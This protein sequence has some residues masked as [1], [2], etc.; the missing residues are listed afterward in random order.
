[1]TSAEPTALI[2]VGGRRTEVVV[3]LG[4][5]AVFARTLSR[6]VEGLPATAPL[7]AGELRQTFSAYLA[8]SG[9]SIRG[10]YLVGGGAAAEGAEAY[11]AHQLGIPVSGL[12]ELQLGPV[13]PEQ[14]A[15]VPRFAKAIAL[16][17]SLAP[18]PADVDLRQGELTFQRGYGFLK[19]KI[20][21]LTGLGAAI[22]ISFL[23][24]TWAELRALGREN[25]ALAAALSGLSKEVLAEETSDPARAV[26]LLERAK[27]SE[28]ADPMPHLDA[29]GVIVELSKIIP[30][31]ITHD[32]EE[33]DMQR[34]HVKL[35][36]V[37]GSA[38]DAQL[39]AT[40]IG[41]H[42]CLKDPKVSKVTQVINSDRQKYVLEFDVRC[43]DDASAKKK[44]KPAGGAAT[45]TTE[46][47]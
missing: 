1:L 11:L 27:G 20:P 22:F 46:T 38:A 47:P 43:P 19:D 12:P 7:L 4:G 45:T 39:I 36:G 29:F 33:F 30:N 16:A 35:N 15:L 44:K 6:G 17:L 42:R 28:D 34:G 5:E 25:E 23:F 31:S 26:E 24:S 9:E 14:A 40:E 21:L 8:Q 10:A 41:K 13:T 18:R 3:L 37:V 32:I 2:D